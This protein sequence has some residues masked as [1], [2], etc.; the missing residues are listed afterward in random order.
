[1]CEPGNQ[2]EESVMLGLSISYSFL[3]GKVASHE[4]HLPV[5]QGECPSRPEMAQE[6]L[7]FKYP[8]VS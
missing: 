3:Q 2:E 8:M 7:P 4:N 1:M 5:F 6:A